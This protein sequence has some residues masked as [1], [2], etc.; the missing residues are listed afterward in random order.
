MKRSFLAL[1]LAASLFASSCLGPNR[2]FNSITNW[3]AGLSDQDWINEVVFVGLVIIPVYG[4]A[5]LGDYL[6]FNTIDY[7]G[8]NN[9]IN[10]PGPFPDTWGKGR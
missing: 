6:I 7:W 8:G 5:L 3:N 4:I 2:L 1:A 9:P 10:D